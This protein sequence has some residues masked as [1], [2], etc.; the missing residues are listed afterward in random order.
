VDFSIAVA[1]LRIA[2]AILRNKK[3][4]PCGEGLAISYEGE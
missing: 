3:K 1:T 2:V 4:A